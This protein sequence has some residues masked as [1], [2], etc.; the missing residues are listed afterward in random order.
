M[1]PSEVGGGLG[2]MNRSKG[3]PDGFLGGLEMS[4]PATQPTDRIVG[5]TIVRTKLIEPNHTLAIAY[6]GFRGATVVE[7]DD[8]SV[9]VASRM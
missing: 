3:P 7:L 1:L 2:W 6:R 5:R 4:K 8:G 9:L